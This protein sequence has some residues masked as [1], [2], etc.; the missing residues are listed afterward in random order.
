MSDEI[1]KTA[2]NAGI[3]PDKFFDHHENYILWAF[4]AH[5]NEF[6]Q[7]LKDIIKLLIK[8][9]NQIAKKNLKLI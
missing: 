4:I 3:D 8:F 6:E 9:K 5:K 1:I 2:V 7:E